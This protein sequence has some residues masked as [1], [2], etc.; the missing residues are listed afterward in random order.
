MNRLVFGPIIGLAVLSSGCQLSSRRSASV[1][2]IKQ[3][4][5]DGAAG[6]R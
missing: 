6:L 4:K 1:P 3:A 5:V 2:A